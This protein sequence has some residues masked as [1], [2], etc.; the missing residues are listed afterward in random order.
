Q[1]ARLKSAG[2]DRINHNLNTSKR[3]YDQICSTH[4]YGDRIETLRVVREAGMELCCGLIVGMGERDDDV[5]DVAMELGQIGVESIPV[6]FL[7]AIPGTP[8]QETHVLN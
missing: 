6:N 4:T 7:H 8:L 3:F 1:A 5:I 2:V